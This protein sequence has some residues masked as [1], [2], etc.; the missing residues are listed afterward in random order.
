[1][2]ETVVSLREPASAARPHNLPGLLSDAAAALAGATTAAEVLEAR[3]LAGLAYDAGKAAARFSRAKHAHDEVLSAVYRAQ[4]DALE[5]EAL[6]KRRIADEYD[7]AQDRG[8]I[9]TQAD[10]KLFTN[11]KKASAADI[12]ITPNE[13]H[14]ARQIRDALNDN[15]DAVRQA[16]DGQLKQNR[17]PTRAAM[18]KA[19]RGPSL[20]PATKPATKRRAPVLDE[21]RERAA[22]MII[23]GVPRTE[24]AEVLKVSDTV[25]RA[26]QSEIDGGLLNTPNPSSFSKSKQD[27][28][29]SA[30]RAMRIRLLSE[31]TQRMRD[32]DEE[33]RQRVVERGKSYREDMAASKRKADDAEQWYLKLTNNHR[34][35][36]TADEFMLLHL[37]VRGDASEEKRHAAGVVL[38]TKRA[39]LTGQKP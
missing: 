32:L 17:E 12:G 26:V 8:E 4:A 10:N 31:H 30:L 34:P 25:L 20:K 9:R 19:L 14:E 22:A 15:P 36:L 2:S 29:E 39:A 11:A 38:N 16:L 24:I 37:C 7:D 33:V 1:M 6:A 27:Q 3:D 21:V 13:I 35:P 23:A 28:F 18:K 5:I